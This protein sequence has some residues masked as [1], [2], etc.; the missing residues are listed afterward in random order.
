MNMVEK[1]HAVL[2]SGGSAFGL[3][4]AGGVMRYLEER[5]IG[6]ETSGG[7]VPIVSAAV[8]FD[9]A[10]GDPKIRPG[11]DEGYKACLAAGEGPVAEGCVGAGTGAMVGQLYGRGRATKSGLGIASIGVPGGFNVFAV[12]AVNAL[13]DVIDPETG[14]LLAGVRRLDDKGFLRTMEL[15]KA[16]QVPGVMAGSHTVIGA[17]VTDARLNK[18]QANK[19]AQ[20]AHDGLARAVNPSHTMYDGDTLFALSLGDL[21]ADVTVVGALAA[22]AVSRA[23]VSAVLK[24]S[25]LCSVPARCDIG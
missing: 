19:V 9:L 14:M 4:A 22:E 16:G 15:M 18:D 6:Y 2:L 25:V 17:V 1:V 23:I 13:G 24:A 10:I 12:V 5:D 11:A 7:R 8:L 20:M 3:D 21:S